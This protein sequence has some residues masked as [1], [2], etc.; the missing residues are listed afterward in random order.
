MRI[1]Y[2]TIVLVFV[3]FLSIILLKAGNRIIGSTDPLAQ[4]IF[5]I[6]HSVSPEIIKV[7]GEIIRDL[8]KNY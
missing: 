3:L 4:Q 8:V 2:I 6:D 5:M 7:K 1:V